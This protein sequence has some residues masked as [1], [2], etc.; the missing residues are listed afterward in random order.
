MRG[1]RGV[2][3]EDGE[4]W[5]GGRRIGTRFRIL[6]THCAIIESTV[7]A[8]A[9]LRMCAFK[10]FMIKGRST[11]H[12]LAAMVSWNVGMSVTMKLCWRWEQHQPNKGSKL[13]N[14]FLVHPRISHHQQFAFSWFA[15]KPLLCCESSILSKLLPS[16]VSRTIYA[17]RM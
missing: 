5:E 7:F 9:A 15:T 11:A 1:C 2:Y 8:H 13:N 10:S 12:A 16:W 3:S 17:D 6:T 14:C 4:E